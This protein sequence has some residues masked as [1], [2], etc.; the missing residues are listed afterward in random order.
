MA[1]SARNKQPIFGTMVKAEIAG[2]TKRAKKFVVDTMS[3]LTT[4]HLL[5]VFHKS[6]YLEK[7][8]DRSS[9]TLS[10]LM[11]EHVKDCVEFAVCAKRYLTWLDETTAV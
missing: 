1:R 7:S 4:S 3:V 9:P 11:N 8:V 6:T 10:T 5:K 2:S